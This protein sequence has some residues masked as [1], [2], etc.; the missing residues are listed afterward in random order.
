[1]TID[2][3]VIGLLTIIRDELP[4][5]RYDASIEAAEDYLRRAGYRKDGITGSEWIRDFK[6][7]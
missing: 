7:Y 4:G 3:I 6:E 5:D 1:M 2:D